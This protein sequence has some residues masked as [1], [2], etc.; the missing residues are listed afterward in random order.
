MIVQ[1]R[2]K[3]TEGD[4]EVTAMYIDGSNPLLGMELLEDCLVTLEIGSGQREITI[5]SQS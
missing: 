5:S 4:R 2:V 1:C 3:W